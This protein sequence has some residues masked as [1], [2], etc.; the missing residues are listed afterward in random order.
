[1]LNI[2]EE[3]ERELPEK[4][5]RYG[6]TCSSMSA[7]D[8]TVKNWCKCEHLTTTELTPDAMYDDP[9]F[10]M[11]TLAD[12]LPE[13]GIWTAGILERGPLGYLKAHGVLNYIPTKNLVHFWNGIYDLMAPNAYLS[14]ACPSTEGYGAFS[15]PTYQSYWT[16]NSFLCVTVD[17]ERAKVRG[18]RAKF[19]LVFLLPRVF[20]DEQQ[21]DRNE[22]WVWADLIALK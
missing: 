9:Y 20:P 6:A 13:C 15:N 2:R 19:E 16:P 14:I 10:S 21:R 12:N 8:E 3:I 11:Y 4:L 5:A 18:L 1:M 17:E 22:P 7:I